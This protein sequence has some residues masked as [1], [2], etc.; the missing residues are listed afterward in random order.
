MSPVEYRTILIYHLMIPLFPK[1]EVFPIC[2]KVCL[3]NLASMQ[4]INCRGLSS[5]KY[6]H[7]LIRDMFFDICRR[8]RILLRKRHKW[9]SWLTHKK[10]DRHFIRQ[11]FW[12]MDGL[13][14]N[15]LVWIWLEF[16]HLGSEILLWDGQPSE[17]LQTKWPNMRK[18]AWQS[19]HFYIVC[20]R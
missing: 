20:I 12:C 8:A 10:R 6:R 13:V 1:D 19:T 17:L 5:F 7:D 16:P 14:V 18:C 15:M 4:L 3:D 9:T 2:R 11:M